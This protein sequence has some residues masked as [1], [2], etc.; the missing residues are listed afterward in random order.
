M[1]LFQGFKAKGLLMTILA[2]V[3]VFA[4]AACGS[5]NNQEP[6][7]PVV[8]TA[9]VAAPVAAVGT[10]DTAP[11]ATTET[12]ANSDDEADEAEATQD[13]V[14]VYEYVA[15][16]NEFIWAF[17][18]LVEYLFYLIEITEDIE[19]DGDLVDWIT[20]FEIIK[21]ATGIALEDLIEAVDLAPEEYLEA[22]I[23]ITTAV[24]LIYEAMVE[25]ENALIAAILGEGDFWDGIE[26]FVVNILAAD[27]LWS[28]AVGVG[29]LD[30]AI[31]GVWAWEEGIE[32]SPDWQIVFNDD[33]TGARGVADSYELFF[34]ETRGG[35]EL[36]IDLGED[37]AAG[38]VRLERWIYIVLEDVL[39]IESMQVADVVFNY[40]RQ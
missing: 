10:T 20:E 17:E 24:L 26:S 7:A 1:R 21:E 22:H 11:E 16:M 40:N 13:E 12:E 5:R 34:W 39:T 29:E 3:M 6:S 23:A 14:D 38:N 37:V 18:D 32:L 15:A 27:Y 19:T 35:Y 2:V 33:G 31:I 30:P 28:Q 8:E 25:L 36:W 4:L 9:S